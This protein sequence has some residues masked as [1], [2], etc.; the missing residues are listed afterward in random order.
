MAKY[1]IGIDFG[2]LAVRALI[3]DVSNGEEVASAVYEYEHGVM[4]EKPVPALRKRTSAGLGFAASF[5]LC[6]RHA[7]YGSGGFKKVQCF[8]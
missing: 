6:K 3:C 4:T 1:T 2:T 7:V 5:G 8:S